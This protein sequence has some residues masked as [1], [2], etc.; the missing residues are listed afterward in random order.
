MWNGFWE[1]VNTYSCLPLGHHDYT[2]SLTHLA[3]LFS[4]PT[5]P[6]YLRN[7]DNGNRI[8]GFVPGN[9]GCVAGPRAEHGIAYTG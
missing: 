8:S 3:I 4:P 6:V 5:S 1:E 7:T 2:L 9:N